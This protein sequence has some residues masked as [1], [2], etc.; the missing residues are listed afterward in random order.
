M[1]GL[2]EKPSLPLVN[3]RVIVRL[4]QWKNCTNAT[5]MHTFGPSRTAYA[6]ARGN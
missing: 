2:S 3:L 5:E 1:G 6:R 4:W